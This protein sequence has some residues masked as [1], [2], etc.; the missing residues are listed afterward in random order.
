[1]SSQRAR[2]W[3]ELGKFAL[4]Y[5]LGCAFWVVGYFTVER[6]FGLGWIVVIAGVIAGTI[7]WGY[8]LFIG[9]TSALAMARQARRRRQWKRDV[10]A[11][12]DGRDAAGVE[13][14]PLAPTHVTHVRDGLGNL[15]ERTDT[16]HWDVVEWAEDAP[17]MPGRISEEAPPL[18]LGWGLLSRR[19][20][21][22]MP[23]EAPEHARRSHAA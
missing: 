4:Q 8:S 15:W 17:F 11:Y 16:N 1:V 7:S 22:L 12:M 19:L 2:M 6:A 18:A 5:I 14:Q 13:P 21:P 20:G 10:K 3:R 23:V 9:E